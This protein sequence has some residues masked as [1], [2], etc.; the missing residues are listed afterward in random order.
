[1]K[2]RKLAPPGALLLCLL[3]LLLF[4]QDAAQSARA[5]LALCAQTVIPSLFPFFVLSSLLI[6]CGASALLSALLAPLMRPLFGLS[7]AG[8][9]RRLPCR[10]ADCRRACRKRRAFARGGGAPAH[11]L[12]QRG[13][14]LS[15]GHMR[16]GGI[17]LAAR[18]R[19]ALSYPRRLSALHGDTAHTPPAA[20]FRSFFR[21]GG[22][23]QERFPLR[24]PSRCGAGRA[25][26]HFE[27]LRLCRVFH[28]LHAPFAA[29]AAGVVRFFTALR[30]AHRFFRADKRRDGTAS[31]P[32]RLS[33]LR[34]TAGLGRPERP[35]PD[36][37]R[38]ERFRP[39]RPVLSACQGSAGAP[40]R[41][42]VAACAAVSV[43]VR[44]ASSPVIASATSETTSA[45]ASSK[46]CIYTALVTAVEL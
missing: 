32:R 17:Y 19:G 43:P 44:A 23:A 42:F 18:G 41:H 3:A 36:A 31:H 1:M 25:R 6:A 38:A 24:S 45:T 34:G 21:R 46:R 28:G 20:A 33:R 5:A 2:L 35:L 16:R 14:G 30:A 37:Q 4:P 12:Q 8:A 26:G 15:A 11:L 39:L 29:C 9:L 40:L 10:R 13:A 22:A 27:C 7:G